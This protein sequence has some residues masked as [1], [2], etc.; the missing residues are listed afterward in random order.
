MKTYT[1][2]LLTGFFLLM[3][4]PV[5]AQ[6]DSVRA[7]TS[8]PDHPRLLLLKGE[9]KTLLRTI[10]TD[11]VW[12]RVHQT[13]L[14]E[15]D[16]ML[17]TAPVQRI[18]I[19]RRLLDKSRECLRRV[20]FLAY[21]YRMTGQKSYRDRAEQELLAVSAFTD[22]N[23][24]HF[25]DVAEMTMAVAIGYDWLYNDLSE[26]SRTK[27][28]DALLTKGLQ[29]S[30]ETRYSGW[31]NASH[32]WN[33][34]CNAGM[35]FGAL[36]LFDQPSA[37]RPNVAR[38]DLMPYIINRAI[39]TVTKPMADY[40]P[41]G[42]Y[43]EGYSYWG[44]GTTFNVLLISALE[45]AFGSDFG[46]TAQPGFRQT[47]Q[48]LLHMTGP[49]GASFNYS[50]AGRGGS[51]QPAM[52]WFAQ[53]QKDPSLLWVERDHLAPAQAKSMLRERVLPAMLVWGNAFMLSQLP[54]P[55]QTAW[56]GGGK[57][58]VALFRSSWQ[59]STAVFV[60][61]KAGSPSVNHG[62]MDVGSFVMEADGVRWASDLGMQ[63]Y[64][65]LES[66]GMNIWG[67]EQNAQRWQV[68]RY[69]NHVHNTLTVNDSL[70]RTNGYA[71]IASHADTPS[72]QHAIT[73]LSTLYAGSLQ[74]ARR[75]VALLNGQYVVVRDELTAL[76]KP[77]TV[78]WTMLTPADVTITGPNSAELRQQGK[79]LTLR[80]Q[81]P[82]QVTMKTWTAEPPN[83]YDAPN[84]GMSLI[85]FE[86]TMP[87]GSSGALTVLLLPG[88]TANQP[89]PPVR[90]L[91]DWP[92]TK[93][94]K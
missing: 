10:Q 55:T 45:K 81:E 2:L 23:P 60:G 18:Q 51:I 24:S 82:A 58:P 74:T 77:A 41:D 92:Q 13:I 16:R 42:A 7:T 43:P 31:Q 53:K 85:G 20:F 9:E 8:L 75:G 32:N 89:L 91:R 52:F 49:T 26:T 33:Q 83:D 12:L 47:A 17:T 73:N 65:S 30:L 61:L 90:S 63:E 68:F 27:L 28:R 5:F 76:A 57:N 67:K 11:S 37:A 79:T 19:G 64:N 21:A 14:Q 34:V 62:H 39:R 46:L 93:A 25:L 38:P 69:R 88:A 50:D 1:R 15:C 29:P 66:R 87:A 36:A 35:A 59:D 44:Y 54:K 22:W 70:Q 84:P 72:F 40:A 94:G 86:V 80:V 56:V 48:Y 6:S 78:R 3:L 71:A 4:Q